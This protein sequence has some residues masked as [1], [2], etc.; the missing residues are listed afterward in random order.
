MEIKFVLKKKIVYFPVHRKNF[1]KIGAQ[2]FQYTVPKYFVIHF[3][4]AYKYAVCNSFLRKITLLRAH[5][6]AGE[7]IRKNNLQMSVRRYN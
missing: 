6:Y 7:S 1:L 3:V 5:I 2:N 4:L